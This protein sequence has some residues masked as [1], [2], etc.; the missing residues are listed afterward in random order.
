[1]LLSALM[2]GDTA[3]RQ[4]SVFMSCVP[5]ALMTSTGH[6]AVRCPVTAGDQTTAVY[7]AMYCNTLLKRVLLTHSA[8]DGQRQQGVGLGNMAVAKA[9]GV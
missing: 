3:G 6:S 9:K 2:D 1:M 5:P 8:P 4:A 7:S